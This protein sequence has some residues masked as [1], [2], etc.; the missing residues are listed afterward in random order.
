VPTTKLPDVWEEEGDGYWV[1]ARGHLDCAAFAAVTRPVCEANDWYFHPEYNDVTVDG[2]QHAYA[3][4]LNDGTI[5]YRYETSDTDPWEPVT[6]WG[7][8][9]LNGAGGPPAP[10]AVKD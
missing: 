8:G 3:I 1:L 2:L 6:I 10:P 9:N 7:A 5:D 4:Y